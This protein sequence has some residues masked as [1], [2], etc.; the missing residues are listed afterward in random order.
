MVVAL[1]MIVIATLLASV[2]IETEGK[3]R[4]HVPKTFG[5][6]NGRKDGL[7]RHRDVSACKG[8]WRG[9]VA[10]S[11]LCSEG[12]HICSWNDTAILSTISWFEATH[13]DGCYAINAAHNSG[14][15]R[16]CTPEEDDLAGIG[17]DCPHQNSRSQSCFGTGKIDASCCSAEFK[18]KACNYMPWISGVLCCRNEVEGAAPTVTVSPVSQVRVATGNDVTLTCQASGN[19]VPAITWYKNGFPLTQ[20]SGVEVTYASDSETLTST[21]AIRDASASHTGL[22]LCRAVNP[23]GFAI[24][25]TSDVKVVEPLENVVACRNTEGQHLLHGG[26]LAACEGR[27]KGTVKRA[28]KHLCAP[29]WQVCG[30]KDRR[31]LHQLMWNEV[32]SL[33]GCYAYDAA[34][35]D[36]FACTKCSKRNKGNRMAGIG[37]GCGE[38]ERGFS[39]CLNKGRI[40]VW[41]R[42]TSE[43]RNSTNGEIRRKVSAKTR[44]S[45]RFRSG[46]TSGVMCCKSRG[47][48]RREPVCSPG[49][50]NGGVCREGNFCKCPPGTFGYRCEMLRTGKK[51]R[52]PCSPNSHCNRH[53]VC[54][55]DKGF[56]AL[57]DACVARGKSRKGRRCAGVKCLNGGKCRRGKCMCT[58]KFGGLR[59]EIATSSQS[60]VIIH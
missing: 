59:C 55:C 33:S 54:K 44:G 49:C 9:H 32:T 13:T 45:C 10:E 28:T 42:A 39:S 29:G 17:A 5:C 23:H 19:P 1:R 60:E 53:G 2:V 37:A 35:S 38:V 8:S 14:T 34:T 15:C 47:K 36:Y 30:L 6:S 11:N 50:E 7:L 21:L 57:G 56:K 40:S 58:P 31:V 18:Q 46:F 48:K 26:E 20:Q 4:V 52:T 51:C 27:W 43:I 3:F 25:Y 16:Q 22:Y 24:S 41:G 12:W